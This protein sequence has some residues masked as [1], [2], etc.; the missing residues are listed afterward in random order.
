MATV[1]GSCVWGGGSYTISY[2]YRARET[3]PVCE[4]E[5]AHPAVGAMSKRTIDS[6]FR[7]AALAASVP[8]PVPQST[9]SEDDDAEQCVAKKSRTHNFRE[10][11]LREFSW[12]RYCKEK[13]SMNCQCCSRYPR[14]AG[15]TKFADSV[16]TSQFKHDTLV[17]HNISIKHR[18]YRDM[19]IN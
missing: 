12:L 4:K 9:E 1:S 8:A 5:K 13:N 11:W 7:P 15:N 16:G 19:L 10:D 14:T 6:F 3:A 17:K 18:A 2:I